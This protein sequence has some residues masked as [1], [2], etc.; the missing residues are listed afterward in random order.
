MKDDRD[1][2]LFRQNHLEC[3]KRG[4]HL[5]S[6]ETRSET[7]F[8]GRIFPHFHS[9]QLGYLHLDAFAGHVLKN[10]QEHF[11]GIP[12]LTHDFESG[13]FIPELSGFD[14]S[15]P[16]DGCI[17]F[18]LEAEGPVFVRQSNCEPTHA[19]CQRRIEATKRT[20]FNYDGAIGLKPASRPCPPTFQYYDGICFHLIED[21]L[22]FDEAEAFCLESSPN[23]GSRIFWSADERHLRFVADLTKQSRI[24]RF[25]L[26]KKKRQT[27]WAT[28]QVKQKVRTRTHP[29][30]YEISLS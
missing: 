6:P 16:E 5:W 14:V 25:W 28:R 22:T 30:H 17:G 21:A 27:I 9:R 4:M 13:A 23:Y 15:E 18:M 12:G 3:F 19:I 10:D 2:R 24:P 8:V 7:Q 11:M 29:T 20:I 26:G 1:E